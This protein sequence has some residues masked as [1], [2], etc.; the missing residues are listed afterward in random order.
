VPLAAL[1]YG[2]GLVLISSEAGA[3]SDSKE[4]LTVLAKL[5]D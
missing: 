1:A 3:E 2:I 4:R 5:P